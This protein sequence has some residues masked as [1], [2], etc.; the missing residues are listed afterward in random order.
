MAMPPGAAAETAPD[1]TAGRYPAWQRSARHLRGVAFAGLPFEPASY[2]RLFVDFTE[3]PGSGSGADSSREVQA[4]AEMGDG[5]GGRVLLYRT[6]SVSCSMH[7]SWA[8]EP[9]ELPSRSCNLRRMLVR[10][11]QAPP[12]GATT[13]AETRVVWERVDLLTV[14]AHAV[15][16]AE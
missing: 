13:E 9:H 8:I 10:L 2:C 3:A 6:A 15:G 14:D 5:G 16:E 4:S 7:P 11:R 1:A 12:R